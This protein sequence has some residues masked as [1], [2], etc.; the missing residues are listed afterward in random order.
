MKVTSIKSR[1]RKLNDLARKIIED[2]QLVSLATANHEGDPWIS[3]VVYAYDKNW[4]LYFVSIRSSKHC[5]N[6]RLNKNVACAI[7]DSR[8]AWGTGTGLQIEAEVEEVAFK[9]I[10]KAGKCYM[11]RKYP[12]PNSDPK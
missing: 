3:P 11:S 7:Y 10:L 5:Q 8:H 12:Y 6:I 9:D 4:N 1:Q 2:N